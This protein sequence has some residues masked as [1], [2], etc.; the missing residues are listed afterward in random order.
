MDQLRVGVIGAGRWS[1]SAHLPGWARSPLCQ[2]VAVCDLHRDLAEQRAREF[3]IP[4]V[5]TDY[6]DLLDR[7]DID[8]IDVCTRDEHDPLVFAALAAGKH[9]LCEKPVAHQA[10]DVWRAAAIAGSKGLKTKVGLTFRYAPA[11][12]Y[13][14]SLIQEGYIGRPFIFNGF[15][16]NSQWLDPDVPA[17]KRIHRVPPAAGD[18]PA[19]GRS[20]RPE[21]IS[22][23]SLEGYGAPII[24]IGLMVV[25]APLQSV[26]GRLK[27]FVPERRRTNLDTAREPIN[28]DD[29]DIFLGEFANGAL[30]SIQ[31]SFVTVGNYPGI[32]ARIYGE[33]GALICRLVEEFGECQSLHAAKPDAVEFRRLEIPAEFFPPGYRPGE[34]WSSLFYAN[35]VHDFAAEILAGPGGKNEGDFAQ[36]ARVQQVI[37]A[38]ERS[39]RARAW[40][41]VAGEPQ[42]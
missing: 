37:N 33:R 5:T 38:V 35:L 9:V 3:D 25:G 28:M 7:A 4:T 31:S 18:D 8:V 22:V 32:E 21:D 39:H 29:G 17:D 34:P 13:M 6:R 16:Q 42:G 23:H 19:G 14:M 41:G 2:L 40:T 26:V 36:S 20:P 12:R 24:D 27:N 10:E 11:M 30:G 1:G 15:E